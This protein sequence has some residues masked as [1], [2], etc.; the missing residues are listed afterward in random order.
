MIWNFLE[1]PGRF[2]LMPGG[3]TCRNIR[4]PDDFVTIEGPGYYL[5]DTIKKVIF[6]FP[7]NALYDVTYHP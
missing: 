2:V 3:S 4:D 1:E 5:Y 7:Q 6:P